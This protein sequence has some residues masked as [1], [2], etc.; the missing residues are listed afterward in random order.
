M[1][2][3]LLLLILFISLTSKSQTFTTGMIEQG[4]GSSNIFSTTT[5]G[6]DGKFYCFFNDGNFTH[7]SNN[8]NPVYRLVR[9]ETGSSSWVSVANLDAANIPGVIISSS[10]TMF[11]D[12]ISLEIDSSG[13]FH[14]LMNVYTSNGAEIKYAYSSNGSSWTYTTVDHSNNQTNYSFA[15]LQLK[16]DSSNY[17]HVYYVIKNIGSGGI[18]SR[19]YSIIHKFYNGSTWNSETAHTQTGGNGTGANDINMMS[20][21]VDGNNKSHIGFVAETNGSGTD[22]SLLYINNVSGT[23]TTPVFLATGG[24]GSPAADRVNI[25]TDTNNKQHIIYR[26][27]N[28]TY[29]LIYTTNKT[30]SWIG[31]QINSNLTSGIISASDSYNAFT[32]NNSNDLFLAYNTSPTTTNIGQVNYACLFNGTTTWQTGSVFTGNSRTGQYISAEFNNS[33]N[34]MITFDHF[35]DPASTG[36]S[37]SYGPPNNPRQ[38]QYATTTVTNLSSDEFIKNNFTIYP[39]P[40]NSILFIEFT[41]FSNIKIE[42]LDLNGRVIQTQS[43]ENSTSVDTSGLSSG[44][45]LIKITTPENSGTLKI[46]K[47]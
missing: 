40:T 23:W 19:V 7:T 32:R 21:S 36:G 43:S 28:T 11:N 25:L 8:V 2:K 34:A 37:P 33:G 30:G 5:I 29:K 42:I 39:N 1:K 18:S 4:N 14:I 17:P 35:T 24:T 38:L 41:K 6:A 31:G 27:N 10:F 12:G 26:E 47:N 22:G 46:I 16:L 45:Y 15:N 20:A 13:G 9:W 44:V 3:K